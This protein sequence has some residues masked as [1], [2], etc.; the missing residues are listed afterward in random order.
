V[1]FHTLGNASPVVFACSCCCPFLV[2]ESIP[3][4]PPLVVW[5]TLLLEVYSFLL[6]AVDT[7]DACG[8]VGSQGEP[9]LVGRVHWEG[10]S[11]FGYM[12]VS[13]VWRGNVCPSI[14]L[15][16]CVCLCAHVSSPFIQTSADILYFIKPIQEGEFC[17][18]YN[19]VLSCKLQHSA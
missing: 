17:I 2:L 16:T 19:Y 8:M 6:S 14:E 15:L 5:L 13:K 7:S 3:G 11:S 12:Y 4:I 1:K 9:P 18:W 10:P